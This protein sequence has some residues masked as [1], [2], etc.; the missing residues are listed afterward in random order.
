[1]LVNRTVTP[2]IKLAGTLLYTW[3]KWLAQEHNKMSPAM[4]A[5]S[6]FERTNHETTAPPE[7]TEENEKK[8]NID[9]TTTC[10]SNFR[11]VIAGKGQPKM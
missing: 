6:G 3:V 2:S 11:T 8:K 9:V 10:M 5:G 7:Y 4:A 1:M